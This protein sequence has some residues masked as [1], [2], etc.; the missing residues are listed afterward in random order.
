MPLCDSLDHRGMVALI[1]RQVRSNHAAFC[2]Y[3]FHIHM[4]ISVKSDVPM[5]RVESLTDSRLRIPTRP[6]AD[7]TIDP[8][9]RIREVCRR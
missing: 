1:R 7:T 8:G 3:R 4:A 6:A 9:V 2:T 5:R